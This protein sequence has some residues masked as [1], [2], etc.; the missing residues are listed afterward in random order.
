[1]RELEFCA[2]YGLT[3]TRGL[4]SCAQELAQAAREL[5]STITIRKPRR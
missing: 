1:M 2:L 4:V 3:I 5:A